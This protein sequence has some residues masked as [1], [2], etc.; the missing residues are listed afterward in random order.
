MSNRTVR[1]LAV[2]AALLAVSAPARSQDAA[3]LAE[4]VQKVM[5]RP[6]FRHANFGVEVLSLDTGKTVYAVNADKLFQPGSTTKLLTMGTALE[7]LGADYRFRTRVYRTGEIGADGTLA[8]DLV[9]VASGDP[10][11]SGRVRTDGTLAFENHDHSYDASPDTRAVPG[12]PLLAVREIAAQIKARGVRAVTGHVLVDASLYPEGDRELGTGVVI[13]PIMVNDNIVDVASGPGAAEGAPADLKAAPA[14]AYARFVNQ[15]V[16]GKPDSEPQVRWSSDVAADDGTHTVT[17][18]GS[19]P[20]GKPAMLFAYA[21]PEP[22]RFA[23]IVLAEA[24]KEQG[25]RAEPRARADKRD[26][27]QLAASYTPDRAVAEHVSPPLGEEVKVTLK[28]SQN[29]HASATPLLLGALLS[30]KDKVQSGFDLERDFLKRAGLDLSGASQGDGAGG[31]AH[32]TP[33]FMASYLAFMARQKDFQIFFDAL[34]V[35][36][37][38]GTLWNIQPTSPAAGHVRAKTG[39]Y[40]EPDPLNGGVIVTGKGL[41]GYTTTADGR[42]LA[43]AIYVN[44]V[45]LASPDAVTTVV[46]QALG[47]IAAAV[48]EAPR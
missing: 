37:R 41:A 31:L 26:A 48:Y 35:L 32:F 25:V 27:K 38:D 34:P 5:G 2:A 44:N 29:L 45:P 23:E 4:R 16:T 42:R 20:A 10:N 6:E 46:G 33:E 28:V 1:A 47:E 40:V 14:T 17:A 43:F 24:L 7:L 18:T 19:V 22:S 3:T 39:T 12:D 30:K 36:G 13:S 15:V 21:V 9:L 11:L 8:G